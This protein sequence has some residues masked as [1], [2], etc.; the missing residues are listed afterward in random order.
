MIICTHEWERVEELR[1][2]VDYSC[3]I[4]KVFQCRCRK[5]GKLKNKKFWKG[6]KSI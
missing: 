3:Y 1:T 6:W 5:C 4:V 2:Y